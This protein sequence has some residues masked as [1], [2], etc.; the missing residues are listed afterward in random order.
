LKLKIYFNI[1]VCYISIEVTA[2]LRSNS[3][4]ILDK[5]Q[6]MW[7]ELSE[8]QGNHERITMEGERWFMLLKEDNVIRFGFTG[9]ELSLSVILVF[10][11]F[12]IG[13]LR[14]IKKVNLTYKVLQSWSS[15]LC[16]IL[17]HMSKI[18]STLRDRDL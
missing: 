4:M 17:K 7:S 12:V 10:L 11:I 15:N 16:S 8:N 14:H 6:S 18:S 1:N 2:K 3:I 13:H 5:L 9:F